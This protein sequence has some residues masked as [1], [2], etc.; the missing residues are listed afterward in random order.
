MRAITT[1]LKIENKPEDIHKVPSIVPRILWVLHIWLELVEPVSRDYHYTHLSD[2]KTKSQRVNATCQRSH[3]NLESRAWPPSRISDSN[4][5]IWRYIMI[6]FIH[7]FQLQVGFWDRKEV[8][9]DFLISLE[10]IS[11][12]FPPLFSSRFPEL[13]LILTILSLGLHLTLLFSSAQNSSIPSGVQGWGGDWVLS[14]EASP[15]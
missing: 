9:L 11:I 5:P 12:H 4:F 10:R 14:R 8:K 13:H 15:A 2:E 6:D 1:N 3:S 7:I